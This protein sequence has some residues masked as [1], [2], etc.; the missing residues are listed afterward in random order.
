MLSHI[1]LLRVYLVLFF[2]FFYFI[3]ALLI[4]FNMIHNLHAG[5]S[6]FKLHVRFSTIFFAHSIILA[7]FTLLFCWCFCCCCCQVLLIFAKA[8]C[9]QSVTVME[10]NA[11]FCFDCVVRFIVAKMCSTF[12]L[13]MIRWYM[14]NDQ[15]KQT[16]NNTSTSTKPDSDAEHQEYL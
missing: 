13:T 4:I 1:T 6:S 10:R 3:R 7:P 14:R 8:T 9:Y 16:H 5:E 11:R 12:T 2:S 15:R